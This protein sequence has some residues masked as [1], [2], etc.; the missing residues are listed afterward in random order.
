MLAQVLHSDEL[1]AKETEKK[2]VTKKHSRTQAKSSH[3]LRTYNNTLTGQDTRLLAEP[4][5]A[6]FQSA[7][8]VTLDKRT[9]KKKKKRTFLGGIISIQKSY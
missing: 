7:S 1:N 5:L 6:P 8:R 4:W 2:N 3:T 9:K